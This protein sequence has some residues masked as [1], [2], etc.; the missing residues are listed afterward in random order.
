MTKK[1]RRVLTIAGVVGIM[2]ALAIVVYAFTGRTTSADTLNT[3]TTGRIAIEL[4]ESDG[5]NEYVFSGNETH[6]GMSLT[7][8][9]PGKEYTKIVTVK[10]TATEDAWVRVKVEKVYVQGATAVT[11][12]TVPTETRTYNAEKDEWDISE[13]TKQVSLNPDYIVLQNVDT[14]NWE[15][16]DGYYYYRTKLTGGNT[17]P[18]V[19]DGVK[20]AEDMDSA[21]SGLSVRVNVTAEAVQYRNN[22]DYTTAWS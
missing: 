7:G 22:T 21:Y 3:I 12:L 13:G 4:H 11:T 15:Y 20:I 8:V 9:L 6:T 5:T 1:K 17:T 14:T 10:N 18:F 19:F 2:A 16:K